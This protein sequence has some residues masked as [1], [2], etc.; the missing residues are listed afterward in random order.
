MGY[1]NQLYSKKIRTV[2]YKFR[3]L[4][5]LLSKQNLEIIYRALVQSHIVYAISIGGANEKHMK[6]L[7]IAQKLIL[8]IIYNKLYRYQTEELFKETKFFDVRQLFFHYIISQYKK[9]YR[10]STSSHDY[11]TRTKNELDVP[12]PAKNVMHVQSI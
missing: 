11:K 9:N 12:K 6:V 5:T 4:K 2:S 3:R 10:H 7:E 8:K 1:T